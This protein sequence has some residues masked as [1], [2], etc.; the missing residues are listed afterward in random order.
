MAN[1]DNSDDQSR[2]E[3]PSLRLALLAYYIELTIHA[4]NLIQSCL[5]YNYYKNSMKCAILFTIFK[6]LFAT[7]NST[8]FTRTFGRYLEE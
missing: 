4:I 5:H 3:Q 1:P 7:L 2:F 6:N 8:Y